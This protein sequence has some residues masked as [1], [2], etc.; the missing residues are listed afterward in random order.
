MHK[1]DLGKAGRAWYWR[2]GKEERGVLEFV[3]GAGEGGEHAGAG[4]VFGG[5]GGGEGVV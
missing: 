2:N 5:D 3:G 4:A 1:S